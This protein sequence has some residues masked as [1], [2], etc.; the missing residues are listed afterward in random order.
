MRTAIPLPKISAIFLSWVLVCSGTAFSQSPR[1]QGDVVRVFT[2]LV[3]T[4]VMVF[5]KGGSFV[6]DLRREDF[7]LRIDGKPRPIEFFERITAGSANEEAQLAAARGSLNT[8]RPVSIGAVPLDRGRT[9][10]FFVDD[11]HLDLAGTELTRKMITHYIDREMSQN[12][13]AAITSASGQVGFLGQLTDNRTVLR[14]ALEQIKPRASPVKDYQR[15]PMTEYQAL[16]ISR[17]DRDTTDYFA[18]Q[19]MRE[20]PMLS[21]ESAVE[22]VR[23]RSQSVLAQAGNI[24]R[25]TLAGLESLVKSSAH[26]PG[27]K[28]VFF[29]SN[30]FF[31]DTRNSDSL[32]RIQRLTSAA[33][34]NGVV[35]YSMDARGLVASLFD[36]SS[37]VAFDP[38]G[39]LDR[40]SGGELNATQD[41][42]NALARDTG[43]RPFFN[44]NELEPGLKKALVE[45]STYYL[46]AWKPEPGTKPGSK[47]RKIEVKLVGK[48]GLSVRVRRG[49]FDVEPEPVAKGDKTAQPSKQK[50]P[51]SELRE[52]IVAPYPNREIPIALC[53]SYVNTAEKGEMLSTSMQIPGEFLSYGAN[54][55]KSK[56]IVDLAGVVYDSKGRVGARFNERVT[57]TSAA[58][59]DSAGNDAPNHDLTYNFPIFLAPGLYQVRV[60]GRDLVSG[61]V[62]SAHAWIEVPNVASGELALSSLLI[63]ERD[64]RNLTTASAKEGN[65]DGEA[66]FSVARRFHR[67]SFLRFLVFAYNLTPSATSQADAVVQVQVVR[68]NQPVVTTAQRKI[69]PAASTDPKRLAYAAEIPLSGLTPGLYMLNVTI[70]DRTSKKTATQQARFEIF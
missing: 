56:A 47:F 45:T 44:T 69:D 67:D 70:L 9:I 46:L 21:Q 36:A 22:M 14:M 5:D 48:P 25:V 57:I 16:L 3:Q 34:R 10:L 32:E 64:S 17:F 58:R 26:I 42:M 52:A 1:E 55:D 24:S 41:A 53:L 66:S 40:S 4:D 51:E 28:V 65:P 49:F 38:S 30:G 63:G 59:S 43:G 23:S 20:I 61:R 15:P 7:E 54:S 19:L 31:L 12:D 33:A 39:R 68:D 11:M 29:I 62:G 35:I 50:T 27:R 37:D 8:G 2:E 60:G 18:E 13:E 6:K